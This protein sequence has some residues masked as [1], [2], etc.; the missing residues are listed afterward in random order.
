MENSAPQ[1]STL[2]N[3]GARNCACFEMRDTYEVKC[4]EPSR[5]DGLYRI[6]PHQV[7]T[8]LPRIYRNSAILSRAPGFQAQLGVLEI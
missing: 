4:N 7:L 3:P 5:G 2:S 1:L 8:E 6:E